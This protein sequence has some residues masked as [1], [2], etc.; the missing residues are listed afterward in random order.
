M[1]KGRID[2]AHVLYVSILNAL[3]EAELAFATHAGLA[4][5]EYQRGRLRNAKYYAGLCQRHAAQEAALTQAPGNE[6]ILLRVGELLRAIDAQWHR[7][8]GEPREGGMRRQSSG[9]PP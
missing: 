3:P 8:R 4:E 9:D 7:L 6:E 1:R 2:D 5:A